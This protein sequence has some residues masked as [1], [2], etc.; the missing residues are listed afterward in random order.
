ML[1][2]I[3]NIDDSSTRHKHITFIFDMLIKNH[4]CSYI[5]LDEL[6]PHVNN[7]PDYFLSKFNCIP[8]Y[9]I[10]FA[11]IGSFTHLIYK[12]NKIMKFVCIIDDIHHAK[13]IRNARLPV[14]N[15]ADIILSTYAYEYTYWHLPQPK[16]LFFFPHSAAWIIDFNEN[17]INKVLISG[18]VSNTYEDRLFMYN[19]A[20]TNT[21][22]EILKCDFNYNVYNN[23]TKSSLLCHENYYKYLNNYICCFVDTARNYMLAKVF[24]ILASGSLLLCMNENIIDIF[25]DIGL[26]DGINYISCNRNNVNDK[27]NFITDIN[28][29]TTINTIRKNGHLL[30]INKHHYIHRYNMLLNI[31]TNNNTN[32]F[33]SHFSLKTSKFNSLYYF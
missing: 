32:Y 8:S 10:T 20:E 12:I 11:G 31:L 16:K 2:V 1:A 7:L 21:N 29:I 4:N 5:S 18:R 14:L 6:S 23:L 33:N 28:N 9:F 30:L 13:S 26:E 27:V 15:K 17:P 3:N 22:L 24:E 25:K 19:L